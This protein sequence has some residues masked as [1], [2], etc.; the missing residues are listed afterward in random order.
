M[1]MPSEILRF[2]NVWCGEETPRNHI[3]GVSFTLNQGE[4]LLISGPEGSGK[5]IILDLV[6]AKRIPEK[7]AIFY[8]GKEGDFAN[9]QEVEMLRF[10]VGYVNQTAG[11]IN[12]LSVIENIVLP[13]RYHTRM[14]DDELFAAAD[15]W[16]ERYELTHKKNTRPVGLSAS[17]AI[18]TAIIRAFIVEPRILLLDSIVDALCPLAS[19]HLLT[20]LFEDIK[21]RGISYILSSYHPTIF[22]GRELQFMLVY[23][24]KVVF[25]GP[26]AEIKKV[27]NPYLAQYRVYATEGPMHPF[28]TEI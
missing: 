26:L 27:D 19:R 28:N 18:R 5:S 22:V 4:G 16:I 7:G 15:F 8:A 24:G 12:N 21:L 9:T 10:S 6:L 3:D 2:E 14:K 13:L 11:L 20:L 17:E 23:R 1:K 25:Q